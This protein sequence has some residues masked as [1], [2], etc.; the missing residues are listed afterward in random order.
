MSRLTIQGFQQRHPWVMRPFVI[1]DAILTPRRWARIGDRASLAIERALTGDSQGVARALRATFGWVGSLRAWII[2]DR[3][4]LMRA[5]WRFRKFVW[6]VT[7]AV[8]VVMRLWPRRVRVP[9]V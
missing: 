9:T 4:L 5:A 6:S 7:W 8:I 3:P 2:R 1:I